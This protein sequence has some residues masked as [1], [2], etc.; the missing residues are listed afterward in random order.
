MPT[1]S[2]CITT[3]CTKPSQ[4]IEFYQKLE[5][6]IVS[7]AEPILV[8]DAHAIIEINPDRYARA[9]IKMYSD[10]WAEMVEALK[11]KTAVH[12]LDNGFLLNDFNG[13]WIYLIEDEFEFQEARSDKKA[14]L[15]GNFAGLSLEA[16]DMARSLEIWKILGFEH[17]SGGPNDSYI[18]LGHPSGFHVSLMKPLSCP[19]LFFN[20]SL[21]YFNSKTNL[22][23]IEKI[24]EAGIPITEE[25]TVFN[26]EGLVDNIIIRDPGGYGFFIFND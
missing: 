4:S 12:K 19:H 25:V 3:P 23:H 24:R 18:V 26:K 11:T 5:F 15:T 10:S 6:V 14:A 7:S 16:S 13:C 9:G 17:A 21:T 2:I 20:P 8:A 22:S 1:I